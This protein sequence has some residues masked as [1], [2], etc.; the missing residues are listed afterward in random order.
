MGRFL[1]IRAARIDVCIGGQQNKWGLDRMTDELRRNAAEALR[2]GRLPN[3]RPERM[4]GG[5]GN[6]EEA[7]T[8]C[9]KVLGL[10]DVSLDLE[11]GD[12]LD[13]T[14]VLTYAVHLQCFSAWDDERRRPGASPACPGPTSNGSGHGLPPQTDHGIIESCG[15][16]NP[17]I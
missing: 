4:W 13:R 7:C 6:G 5:H 2:A 3:R 12:P 17:S 1:P 16:D 10:E 11:Y 14:A 9:G 8:L 15:H